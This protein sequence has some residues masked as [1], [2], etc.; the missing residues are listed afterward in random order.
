MPNNI[1]PLLLHKLLLPAVVGPGPG[2]GADDGEEDEPVAGGQPPADVGDSWD[3]VSSELGMGW[4]N[5]PIILRA[6]F[7]GF[8]AA[9]AV[10]AALVAA[11]EAA[12]CVGDALGVASLVSAMVWRCDGREEKSWDDGCG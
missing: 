10:S 9:F 11:F 8:G 12:E 6:G 5:E 4:K 2:P 1:A 7:W 3:I